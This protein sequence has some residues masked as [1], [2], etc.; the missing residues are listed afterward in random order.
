[1]KLKAHIHEEEQEAVKRRRQGANQKVREERKRK[2]K[3][4][5]KNH[6][7]EGDSD[8]SK[9]PLD[10]QRTSLLSFQFLTWMSISVKLT[11]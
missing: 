8:E 5:K 7:V 10:V 1:M 2:R 11:H 9:C 6:P 4:E 3:G